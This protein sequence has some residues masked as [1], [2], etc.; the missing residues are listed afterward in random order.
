MDVQ[1][2]ASEKNSHDDANEDCGHIGGI[3][4]ASRVAKH[5]GYAV[6]M[7]F[8]TDS[9]YAVANLE[10]VAWTSKE[11]HALASNT[12]D[13]NAIYASKVHFA[14]QFA[15]DGGAGNHNALRNKGLFLIFVSPF[16]W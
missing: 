1:R 10:T 11:V 7:V 13:V 3:Q 12:R 4:T 16:F 15:I 2:N 8:G 14:Q 5:F 9:Y 6:N